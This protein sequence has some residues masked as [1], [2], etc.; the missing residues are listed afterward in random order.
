MFKNTKLSEQS[1]MDRRLV[2]GKSMG[3]SS[4]ASINSSGLSRFRAASVER[5]RQDLMETRTIRTSSN[6]SDRVEPI[7]R[8]TFHRK[9][10]SDTNQGT[11]AGVS[12]REES[13][14]PSPYK[15]FE[16]LKN[17]FYIQLETLKRLTDNCDGAKKVKSE[18]DV[19]DEQCK[20]LDRCTNLV[21]EAHQS[22][23]P[24]TGSKLCGLMRREGVLDVLVALLSHPFEN[25]S[26]EQGPTVEM[27]T[28]YT[29]QNSRTISTNQSFVRSGTANM[30]EQPTGK[31]HLG[32]M[33]SESVSDSMTLSALSTSGIRAPASMT[34]SAISQR[35]R[36]RVI[37]S[38]QLLSQILSFEDLDQLIGGDTDVTNG[39]FTFADRSE[40][41]TDSDE[42]DEPDV[43]RGY[44]GSKFNAQSR[45]V[46]S[47][48]CFDDLFGGVIG[49]SW[50]L[51]ED[52]ELYREY[53][54][55]LE[56]L[57]KQTESLC[58]KLVDAGGLRILIY[59]CRSNDVP[60]L[61]LAALGLA[62]LALFG[63]TE[64]QNMMMLENAIIWLFHLAF[65]PDVIIKYFACLASVV[66]SANDQLAPAVAASRTLEMV[67]PFVRNHSPTDF[68]RKQL[69]SAFPCACMRQQQ[70]LSG[71]DS[72]RPRESKQSVC[73]R[74]YAGSSR[75]WLERLLPALS[76]HRIE[77]R[78]LAAFH[79]CVEATLKSDTNQ[80]N[81]FSEIGAVEKLHPLACSLDPYESYLASQTLY[82][83]HEDIPYRL[84]PQVP[85]WTAEDVQ[86]W[87]SRTDF[88]QLAPKF[89]ELRVDGDLLLRLDD[90]VLKT[91]FKIEN[92]VTRQ[93]LLR[94]MSQLKLRADYSPKDPTD[95]AGWLIWASSLVIGTA[96]G[97]PA[98]SA[99]PP[100]PASVFSPLPPNSS[101]M[102]SLPSGLAAYQ[103]QPP[104]A[105]SDLVQHTYNMLS[106]GVD[107][108]R[109]HLLNDSS[110]LHDCHI[111]NGI[112]RARILA[113]IQASLNFP[114]P[115]FLTLE[116]LP[117]FPMPM[118]NGPSAQ[119]HLDVFISY[120]RSNGSQLASLLKVFLQL[121]GYRVFLDIDELPA[122]KFNESLQS[123]IKCS[124]NFLLVL[125]PN[126]LD[127][128]LNDVDCADWIHRET[129]CALT[130]KRNI[131]P[132]THN[133]QWP[134][135]KDLP[136]DMR[137]IID[138]N[139]VDWVHEYQDACVDRIVKFMY[140]PPDWTPAS[141]TP[142]NPYPAMLPESG[143]MDLSTGPYMG[144]KKV[145]H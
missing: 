47:Q 61:R 30:T 114:P 70:S 18:A 81:I 94:E 121:R 116:G 15:T 6:S 127:R 69:V 35:N 62:N 139:A 99:S 63:G 108:F 143:L 106:A 80:T 113:A 132:I 21:S 66:L 75:K 67:L 34:Q 73:G 25:R 100:P 98:S 59:A 110:L 125:S 112:H 79:F 31:G 51:R 88:V 14:K 90:S 131:I 60:T 13:R 36:Q 115:G 24:D 107:R 12:L 136:E 91:D 43:R 123:S 55:I 142:T 58:R 28:S 134:S 8:T 53:L 5:T 46:N 41:A 72:F 78:I 129:V 2:F 111:N 140:L 68:A 105:N 109:L 10:L 7:C 32:S 56:P 57:L 137:A 87:L 76:A 141:P 117:R 104:C 17:C 22:L 119:F 135:A 82:L 89:A 26:D 130:H 144:H 133:F 71:H 83:L 118:G 97:E 74:C 126:A 39:E 101:S 20:V 44:A 128:C 54:A 40:F 93:R 11:F 124:H 33:R 9:F 92:W 138:Y 23:D 48:Q 64:G 49:Q 102:S 96:T 86:C 85:L 65:H 4:Q 84:T 120:R 52:V 50:E 37:R 95:L 19:I 103:S 77:A 45:N 1:T 29:A 42:S 38:A 145:I 16:E 122:G 27:S 3:V